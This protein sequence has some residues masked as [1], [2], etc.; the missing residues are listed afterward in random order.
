MEGKFTP[1][2]GETFALITIESCSISGL[3]NT[4]PVTGSI[5]CFN[6][7]ATIACTEAEVTTQG[8]LKFAGQK[9]GIEVAT[10]YK[11]RANSSQ[12]YS[13]VAATTIP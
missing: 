11:A 4:F 10:T 13:P 8:T 9:A 12:E 5:K 3:N 6:G 7:G 2:S 1:A